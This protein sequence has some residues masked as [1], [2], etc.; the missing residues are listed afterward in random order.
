MLHYNYNTM[1]IQ[2]EKCKIFLKL[3]DF[4]LIKNYI[5]NTPGKLKLIFKGSEISQ[6]LLCLN[7]IYYFL[8]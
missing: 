5:E 6:H 7:N 1:E 3:L 2:M 4:C 8:M